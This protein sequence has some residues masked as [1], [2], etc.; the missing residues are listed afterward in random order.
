MNFIMRKIINWFRRLFHIS[1]NPTDP[2]NNPKVKKDYEY[3]CVV[4]GDKWN[5]RYVQSD[6]GSTLLFWLRKDEKVTLGTETFNV[7]HIEESPSTYLI[8]Y[9]KDELAGYLVAS[10]KGIIRIR[11]D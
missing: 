2:E 1:S 10:T 8:W 9:S 11:K 5:G 3:W 4:I 7:D 6:D